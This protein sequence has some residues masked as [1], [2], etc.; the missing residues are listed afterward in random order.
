MYYYVFDSYLN[1]PKYEKQVQDINAIL[2]SLTIQGERGRISPV[3]RLDDIMRDAASKNINTIIMIG[4]ETSFAKAVEFALHYNFILGY[5]P[6]APNDPF[7]H[8]L[9]IDSPH[10][11]GRALM[12][13]RIEEIYPIQF[14]G[15]YF[16]TRVDAI[17]DE[18]AQGGFFRSIFRS[19][20]T[21]NIKILFDENYFVSGK[22]TE[23]TIFNTQSESSNPL[24]SLKR[25]NPR[26]QVFEVAFR[27]Q[28]PNYRVMKKSS[29]VSKQQYKKLSPY[30]LLKARKIEILEPKHMEFLMGNSVLGKVPAVIQAAPKTI[31]L[32]VG[33]KREF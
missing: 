28:L 4:N 12:A 33:R 14:N 18:K 31:K 15:D 11:A 9:G 7:G 19:G 25:I 23:L 3:R 27:T 17:L 26:D 22:F 20:H 1:D 24:V 29:G 16:L 21:A 30:N 2:N 5:V 13:R 6:V 32:I 10:E 8:Q